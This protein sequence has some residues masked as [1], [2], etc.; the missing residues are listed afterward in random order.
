MRCD[1]HMSDVHTVQVR[2]STVHAR[3]QERSTHSSN[4]RQGG[5]LRDPTSGPSKSMITKRGDRDLL[6]GLWILVDCPQDWQQRN[7]SLNLRE[8]T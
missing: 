5:E 6:D 7:G 8:N 2:Y 1:D 4:G 3:K